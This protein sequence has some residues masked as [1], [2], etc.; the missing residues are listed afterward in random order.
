MDRRFE[1]SEKASAAAR[2]VVAEAT[3]NRREIGE[4]RRRL[5]SLCAPLRPLQCNSLESS[6]SAKILLGA[7]VWSACDLS[8][9]W[10]AAEPRW[11]SFVKSLK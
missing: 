5:F 2:R 4:A 1:R 7:C 10:L 8:P 11:S 9:L 3:S 6:N